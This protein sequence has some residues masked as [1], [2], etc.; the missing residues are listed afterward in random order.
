LSKTASDI[1]VKW[2]RCVTVPN[3]C[4]N[5]YSHSLMEGDIADM[6]IYATQFPSRPMTLREEQLYET[7]HLQ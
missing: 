3:P 6:L 1:S 5:I 2:K 4:D 7:E